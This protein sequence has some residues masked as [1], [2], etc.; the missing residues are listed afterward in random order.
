MKQ[1]ILLT[2]LSLGLNFNGYTQT[3]SVLEDNTLN[4]CD[5]NNIDT[6]YI[7]QNTIFGNTTIVNDTCFDY[8]PNLN[9]VGIDSFCLTTCTGALC[10]T[11]T[12]YIN[13]LP[14]TETITRTTPGNEDITVCLADFLTT[15]DSVSQISN[16]CASNGTTTID[17]VNNCITFL[18]D[19][20]TYNGSGIA[21]T[22]TICIS[23]C[24]SQGVCDTTNMILTITPVLNVNC[25]TGSTLFD[26]G[27]NGSTYSNNEN[28]VITVCPGSP[29]FGVFTT[30]DLMEIQ[31]GDQITI[32]NGNSTASPSYP[33]MPLDINTTYGIGAQFQS[34]V[35]NPT[36]CLTFEFSSNGDGIVGNYEF[37]LTCEAR[38]QEVTSYIGFSDPDTTHEDGEI[39]INVCLGDTLDIIG[40]AIFPENNTEYTQS[41]TSSTFTWNWGDNTPITFN[42]NQTHFYPEPGGYIVNLEVTDLNGCLNYQNQVIKVRVAPIPEFIELTDTFLCLNQED[43][44]T[45][46]PE[47]ILVAGG[48][49][50][51]GDT[52]FFQ[53][54]LFS[55]DSI[56][57][58]DGNGAGY[59]TSVNISSFPPNAT[60][61]NCEDILNVC[62]NM[63]HSY[64]GDLEISLTCPNGQTAI[65]KA[66]PGGGSTYIG[67]PIDDDSNLNPGTGLEYC[68]TPAGTTTLV[69][70]NTQQGGIA[71]G[72]ST[73]DDTFVPGD[74][75]PQEDFTNF[76]GCPINGQWTLNITDNLTVDNGYI[77]NWQ[78]DI[79]QCQY[80]EIDSFFMVYGLG[81]WEDDPIITG[82]NIDSNSII[83]NPDSASLYTLT[84]VIQDQFE[85]E[86]T[87]DYNVLVEGFD[88][89]ATPKD[90]TI[91][92][93]ETVQLNANVD[94]SA[95]TCANDYFQYNIPYYKET[96]TII[97]FNFT[98]QDNGSSPAIAMPFPFSYFCTNATDF[99]AFVDGYLSFNNNFGFS[100]PNNTSIP[101]GNIPNNLIALMWDDLVDSAQTSG[102]FI[103]GT[104]PNRKLV[105]EYNLVHKGGTPNTEPVLGQ[106]ILHETSNIIDIICENCQQDI[107]DPTATQGIE[108]F[109]AS[110]GVPSL[111]RNNTAW[112]STQSAIRFTPKTSLDTDY[113]ISWTPG[114]TLNNDS[115]QSPLA[116]PTVT[117]E[118]TVAISDSNNCTYYDTVNVNVGSAFSSDISNDTIICLGESVQ[119]EVSGGAQTFAWTPND[120][121][122]SDT[123]IANPVFSPTTTTTYTVA[124]DST[125]TCTAY[126]S[127][128][129]EVA[130]FNVDSTIIINETCFGD[131]NGSIE[132]F[133]TN[134]ATITNYSIDGGTTFVTTSLFQNLSPAVYDIVVQGAA[135]CDTT[136][137]I[138][139]FG[140]PELLIDS[141]IGVN[142][143]CGNT[144]D[145]SITIYAQGGAGSLE[146]SINNGL[147][148]QTSN[149]FPTLIGGTYNIIVQDSLACSV[150]SN[151][152]LTQP[153]PIVIQVVQ[154]DSLA[155]F[156][157]NNGAIEVSA[158]GGIGN[159]VFSIDN[160]TF[161][162]TTTF[163]GLIADTYTIY[164]RDDNMCI[165]SLDI[166]VEQPD[167]LFISNIVVDS[168]NC[169]GSDIGSLI[170][171][172]AQG[173]SAPYTYAIDGL[174]FGNNNT[175][176][177]IP[178][179]NYQLVIT[180]ANGCLSNQIDTSI[181]AP[182]LLEF[183]LNSTIDATCGLNNG[184]IHVNGIGGT[185]PYTFN[186]IGNPV[187][188]NGSFS[189]LAAG[190]Y[191]ILITDANGCDTLQS[192][193]INGTPPA[194]I[195]LT[196]VDSV[197]CFGLS[198][199]FIEVQADN[200]TAP[201]EFSIDNGTNYQ[202]SGL[203]NNLT[204]N[205]YSIILIDSIGCTDTLTQ[206][207]EEPTEIILSATVDSAS[208]FG[209]NDGEITLNTIGGNPA[210]QFSLTN[211]A[212]LQ[213]N[214]VYNNLDAD[215]Y[216]VYVVD[217]KNCR[218][219]IVVTVEEPDT[220][221][222]TNTIATN[223]SCFGDANGSIEVN[224]S[225][226]TP[227]YTYSIDSLNFQ[228][229]NLINNLDGGIYTVY[230]LD[231][232]NCSASAIDSVDEPA[233]LTLS[234]TNFNNI[235]C[236]TGSDGSIEVTAG[237]GIAPYQYS[238]DGINFQN[239]STFNNL[240]ANN[241]TITVRDNNNCTETVTQILTEPIPLGVIIDSTNLLCFGDTDGSITITS[242]FGETAPYSVVFNGGA[243]Q[244]YTQGMTFNNLSA[245]TYNITISDAN[246][247][248]LNGYSQDV[249][250]EVPSLFEI[251]SVIAV[252]PL[253]FGANNGSITI[254]TN[255][256]G[257]APYEFHIYDGMD[258]TSNLNGEFSN[259]LE[260][261]YAIW[262]QDQNGC[263]SQTIDTLDAPDELILNIDSVHNPSCFG[264]DD[265]FIQVSSVGG[266][267]FTTGD[268]YNFLLDGETADVNGIFS[269]L[270][271]GLYSISVSDDN[272]CETTL[273]VQVQDPEPVIAE[274]T[275]Q[276][277]LIE[278]GDTL[279]LSVILTNAE[280][281]DYIYTWVPS[282]GLSCADCS[283]P[284]VNIYNDEEF[285]LTFY[286]ENGCFT[287]TS[288]YI[289]VSDTLRYFIPNA[290]TPGGF[291]ETN[292]LFE[293][294]GQ[295]IKFVDMMIFN[296][297]GEKIYET[298]NALEGW[299]GTYQN[300]LQNPGVYTY[301]IK[302]TFLNDDQVE[303]KGSITL[304]R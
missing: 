271:E 191:D 200:G 225:G 163:T 169:F 99:R 250:I 113:F 210:Y 204:A 119:L 263:T 64:S 185:N 283:N 69:N 18:P 176:N 10:D 104:A 147:T 219:S 234:V 77:F 192:I 281:S 117:T 180:D 76:V 258:S 106:I 251:S 15:V 245:G 282:E 146:Y 179:G 154:N 244:N 30:M 148:Y 139:I 232:N 287:T 265:G 78:L 97:P 194:E 144:N 43:T 80:P 46:F 62:I 293:V 269:D 195:S 115:A 260:G 262:V 141:I 79:D 259:L 83:I 302:I 140:N 236:N 201:F 9:F 55:G 255:G 112:S 295:D 52:Q 212:A 98:N 288:T 241:Y 290:F 222:I 297:W 207:V 49:F 66:Y 209:F 128:T 242:I 183:I 196:N 188:N 81:H 8:T 143:S 73:I 156:N 256:G 118:Y 125:N 165:D 89:T 120:G 153:D 158:S 267:P 127:V 25:A 152:V 37:G 304:L 2:I 155:C 65:L 17:N 100:V 1:V 193:T 108:N 172:D 268:L 203:F 221:I 289:E 133:A 53:P 227:S 50:I 205:T 23:V 276:D 197:S 264:Y 84:Y 44:L 93:G 56:F 229:N 94:S 135:N 233:E 292:N 27:G 279:S 137:Q 190:A 21:G 11:S 31:D 121:S 13:V 39:Y 257:N 189:N 202:T 249:T 47:G 107:S 3:Y 71:I 42:Q 114:A 111:G 124:L 138:E 228:N 12:L 224:L 132:V 150:D 280:G 61:Q 214:N 51:Q 19:S 239:A 68:F 181:A 162:N 230:V 109:N 95:I 246:N 186:I 40:N 275:P 206:L 70:G 300:V 103:T 32:Y 213:N 247:C 253:C 58:P 130:E 277:T 67:N 57:L 160:I 22:E 284:I 184:E 208:C 36:G 88:V 142:P 171:F 157:D 285:T 5:T 248:P 90:T 175:F 270:N 35:G 151:F 217:T 273:Q 272:D 92:T 173:G 60:I 59:N 274:I 178:V 54:P 7:C 24:N 123:T 294:Y 278:M 159:L 177:D 101:N 211:D 231:A 134:S 286:D 48:Q 235:S 14:V 26:S 63:E 16:V 164:V 218:D 291:D 252:D 75:L 301:F 129:I 136:Y 20:T 237:G 220:L 161:N 238:I 110:A 91:C 298:S 105:I 168:T 243:P 85:C 254:E 216:N 145:G 4:F 198:D 34:T 199:G 170:S 82:I 86:Y 38:C 33:D 122:I 296:R 174:T 126:E 41:E 226:G 266:T 240:N 29:G 303:K 223:I 182:T 167:S 102:Y 45:A 96:G 299:D 261:I 166:E 72:S 87:H 6:S 28:S 187:Q 74:Y 149:T 116:S 215:T 131:A